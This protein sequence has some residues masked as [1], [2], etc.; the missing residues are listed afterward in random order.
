MSAEVPVRAVGAVEGR[1]VGACSWFM[2]ALERVECTVGVARVPLWRC[3]RTLFRVVT[4]TEPLQTLRFYSPVL[5]ALES[6]CSFAPHAPS[7]SLLPTCVLHRQ[8]C[9]RGAKRASK[10]QR[11]RQAQNDQGKPPWGQPHTTKQSGP[12]QTNYTREGNHKE[13]TERQ[14]TRHP[15]RALAGPPAEHGHQYGYTAARHYGRCYSSLCIV[16]H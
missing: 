1:S 13:L 4:E 2:L 3:S 15:R 12:D 10:R 7:L 8:G 11:H 14:S 16:L 9:T 5:R 6:A